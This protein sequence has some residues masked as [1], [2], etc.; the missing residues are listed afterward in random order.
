MKVAVWLAVW[1]ALTVASVIAS[2]RAADAIGAIRGFAIWQLGA[3][4]AATVLWCLRPRLA[5]RTTLRRAAAVP[6]LLSGALVLG[7]IALLGW[8][9]LVSALR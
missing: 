3:G 4:T 2:L 5:P 7:L 8:G 1:T 6:G 9:F